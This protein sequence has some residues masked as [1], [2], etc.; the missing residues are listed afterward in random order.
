[1]Y[2]ST[3]RLIEAMSGRLGAYRTPGQNDPSARSCGGGLD[4][5]N[6]VIEVTNR[7]G[8]VPGGVLD[9]DA[10]ETAGNGSIDSGR[11]IFGTLAVAVLKVPIDRQSTHG[12]E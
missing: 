5:A 11:D 6:R 7:V 9:S 2:G 8:G 3:P 12:R 10:G 1:M 4:A